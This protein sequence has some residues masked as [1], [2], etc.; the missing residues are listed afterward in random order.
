MA[1]DNE[2]ELLCNKENILAGRNT[3][4]AT[5]QTLSSL[6]PFFL[7]LDWLPGEEERETKN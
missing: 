5:P 1:T 2:K 6:F 3:R 7:G 4:P